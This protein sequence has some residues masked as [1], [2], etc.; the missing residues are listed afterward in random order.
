M[1]LF[2]FQG[3]L[4]CVCVCVHFIELFIDMVGQ[5]IFVCMHVQENK[6]N[7]PIYCISVFMCDNN[8]YAQAAVEKLFY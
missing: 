5:Y 3:D 2:Y 4:L 1:L 6:F 8:M 7:I